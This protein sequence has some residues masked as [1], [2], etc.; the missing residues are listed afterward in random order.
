VLLPGAVENAPGVDK[1][2]VKDQEGTITADGQKAEK[3]GT[4][5]STAASGTVIG[6]ATGGGKGA[7]I[8][9]GIGGAVGTAIAM[10]TRGNDVKMDAGTTLEMVIQRDVP[11]DPSRVPNVTRTPSSSQ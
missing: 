1:T 5:A 3:I 2:K 11:L 7:L 10:L 8:G 4:V 9:A 6:A